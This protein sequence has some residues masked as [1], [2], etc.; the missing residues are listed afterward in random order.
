MFTSESAHP[1][2]NQIPMGL[3]LGLQLAQTAVA[4]RL[5]SFCLLRRVGPRSARLAKVA[6]R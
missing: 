1:V 2:L 6:R 5:V 3:S 4:T